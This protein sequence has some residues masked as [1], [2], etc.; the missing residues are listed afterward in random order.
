V[1]EAFPFLAL[2]N[3]IPGIRAGW[4]G[5]QP[6]LE[7]TGDRD[8]AMN[9]L[10]PR[11]QAAVEQFAGNSANWWRAE[12]VHGSGVAVVPSPESIIAPDG[13][14]VVPGVDGLVTAEPGVLLS[15]YVA[16][17]GVIWLAD[18]RTGAIGLLHSGK[19]GTESNILGEALRLMAARFGTRPA[20]VTAV[21]GPCIRPPDYEVDFAHTIGTQASACHVGNFIDC[22]LNTASDP[23][24]FYS[25]RKELGKTGRMMALMTRDFP[26]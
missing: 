8:E 26:P 5:R 21:L 18:R 25:Y 14:P 20:D 10:R 6:D 7:I 12:Q 23:A 3:E 22:Q 11:H 1:T 17:C 16:D 13:L 2:L 4:I 15:I 9:L 19:K 24:R